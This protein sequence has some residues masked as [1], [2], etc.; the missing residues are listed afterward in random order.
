MVIPTSK[1][2]LTYWEEDITYCA[3]GEVSGKI[4]LGNRS[5]DVFVLDTGV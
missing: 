2:R 4:V 3:L 5:G 1:L